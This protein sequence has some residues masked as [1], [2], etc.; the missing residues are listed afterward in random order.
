MSQLDVDD[1][2]KLRRMGRKMT[3]LY[4]TLDPAVAKMTEG[5]TLSCKAGC[6]GCCYLLT[7]VSLPEAVAIAEYFLA[8]V[9]RRNLIPLLMR[10]FWEQTQAIPTGEFETIR[11]SYFEKRIPCT[12]LDE[13]TK[14]CTIYPVRPSACRY[15]FVVSEPAL[16]QPESGQ[17]TVGRVSTLQA[18]VQVLSEA[19]RASSQ[20]KV[21]LSIAPLPV[22]MLWAFKLLIEGRA[23]FESALKDENLGT[24]SL[25]GWTER[26]EPEAT[27]PQDPTSETSA[28]G[29][30]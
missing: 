24:M 23:A 15:H 13:E 8:D 29:S 21:P 17:Q 1:L 26:H 27:Q 2:K 14:L 9:Q 20:A 10:S 11:R 7:L 30:D 5:V 4:E 6:A 12:F 22:V 19:N 28:Q 18:T 3:S 16:C 25:D